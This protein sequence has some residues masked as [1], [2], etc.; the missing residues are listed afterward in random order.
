M[1]SRFEGG[2]R[3]WDAPSPSIRLGTVAAVSR[4]R[5]LRCVGRRTVFRRNLNPSLLQNLARLLRARFRQQRPQAANRRILLADQLDQMTQYAD[6]RL[7]LR[8][9]LFAQRPLAR[10]LQ[11]PFQLFEVHLDH[12]AGRLHLVPP[13]N[14]S[15]K[16]G[17]SGW[18]STSLIERLGRLV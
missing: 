1:V 17:V 10:P 5:L 16:R 9:V 8:M 14:N 18:P 11:Q 6:G 15:R 4:L 7:Q 12:L 2:V 3:D 13:P